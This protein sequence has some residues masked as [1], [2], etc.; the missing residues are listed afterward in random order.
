MT[1]P[2][3]ADDI[4]DLTCQ[5]TPLLLVQ[6]CTNLDPAP[7]KRHAQSARMPGVTWTFEVH[8]CPGKRAFPMLLGFASAFLDGD[9]LGIDRDDL[10]LLTAR[11]TGVKGK[12]QHCNLEA[13]KW[14]HW[15]VALQCKK[16]SDC[17]TECSYRNVDLDRALPGERLVRTNQPVAISSG[18]ITYMLY[19]VE[20]V[21]G[22]AMRNIAV[23]LH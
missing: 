20:P 4:L 15:P 17:Q 22:R 5:L 21:A 14:Q 8:T 7:L 2:V 3:T 12:P 6:E 9:A 1:L 18:G 13:G 10:A 11:E 23:L 19:H 16:Y